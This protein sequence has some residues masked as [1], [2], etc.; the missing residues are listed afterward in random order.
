VENYLSYNKYSY[1]GGLYYQEYKTM[2][3]ALAAGYTS[4][5]VR[6]TFDAH[7]PRTLR[8]TVVL[9]GILNDPACRYKSV[10]LFFDGKLV[11]TVERTD[12][13]KQYL[14][15]TV[16]TT[17]FADGYY[18]SN[19][20]IMGMLEDGTEEAIEH[21]RG[22]DISNN[23]ECCIVKI[24]SGATPLVGA[25][26][27]LFRSGKAEPYRTDGL[28][29]IEL[30]VSATDGES[31]ILVVGEEL[32]LWRKLAPYPAGNRYAFGNDPAL[33]TIRCSGDIL[34]AADGA[35]IYAAMPDGKQYE[36]GTVAGGETRLWVDADS[37]MTFTV[38]GTGILVSE[39]IDLSGDDVVWNLDNA[40]TASITLTHDGQAPTEGDS[41]TVRRLGLE[42]AGFGEQLMDADGGTILVTPGEYSVTGYVYWCDGNYYSNYAKMELGTQSVT[43]E[44]LTLTLGSGA[45]VA[46]VSVDAETVTEGQSVS[47]TLSFTDSN[48]N[49]IAELGSSDAE[50]SYREKYRYNYLGVEEYD[51]ESETWNQINQINLNQI[52]GTATA[53]GAQLGTQPGLRRVVF[54]GEYFISGLTVADAT[55]EFSLVPQET[56]P[57]ATVRISLLDSY[58]Y[59]VYGVF[60]AT[61]LTD[62]EGNAIVREAYASESRDEA[63]I[64]LPIGESYTLTVLALDY[65]AAYLTTCTV[66]LSAAADGDEV[67]VSVTSD[68]SWIAHEIP[69]SENDES[70]YN[71]RNLALAPFADF[72]AYKLAAAGTNGHIE[73]LYVSGFAQTEL[74]LDVMPDSY[75]EVENYEYPPIFTMKHSVDLSA[76]STLQVGLPR[77]ITL[78]V[79][80]EGD[81]AVLTPV[82]TDAY[83][84]EVTGAT[85]TSRN[86]GMEGG[87]MVE[88]DMPIVKPTMVYPVITVYNSDG[89][90]IFEKNTAFL[91][92]TV[93]GLAEGSY[94]ATIVWKSSD[95][96]MSGE[97]INFTI[98]AGGEEPPVIPML[99]VPT[100]F[101]AAVV[102]GA[103]NLSWAAPVNGCA[104]YL[105]LRDGEV[106]AELNG[107]AVI[108]TDNNVVGGGYHM[109]TLYAID[110][111][112]RRSE[113]VTVGAYIST[114]ADTEA[115]AWS[116]NA[117][118]IAEI[119]NGGVNLSWS[120]AQDSG[121]GVTSYLLFCNGEEIAQLFTRRYTYSAVLPN[122]DYVFSVKA[123]DG[124]GNVSEALT[125][126]AVSVPGG[127]LGV[128]LDY[129]SNRLGYMTGKTLSI[130]VQTTADLDSAVVTVNYTRSDGSTG[131]LTPN[132]TGTGGSFTANLS[133]PDDFKQLDQVTVTCGEHVYTCL[134]APVLRCYTHVEVTVDLEEAKTLYPSAVLTL[135]AP[136]V[137]Y[138]YSYPISNMSGTV[139]DN[140]ISDDAYQLTLADSNGNVLLVRKVDFSADARINLG[141]EYARFLQLTVEGGYAG[142]AVTVTFD[143]KMVGGKLDENGT[144]VWS[145]GGRFLPVGNSATVRIP[146][147][148]YSE[149]ITFDKVVNQRTVKPEALGYEIVTIP[150]TVVDTDGK[151]ISGIEVR[152]TGYNVAD[153]KTTGADGTCVFTFANRK[154][155]TS[156]LSIQRQRD[157]Q[158]RCWASLSIAS[159]GGTAV[160]HPTPMFD[161]ILIRPVLNMDVDTES[162]SFA[163]NGNPVSLKDGVLCV[164]KNG[165]WNIGERVIVSAEYTADGV[166]Y[167]GR[168]GYELSTQTQTVELSMEHYVEVTVSLTDN[169]DPMKG[170]E[171][172]FAVYNADKE[173]VSSFSTY[174]SSS[175]V[176][177]VGGEEY[178]VLA[179]WSTIS[180]RYDPSHSAQATFIAAEGCEVA[181][182]MVVAPDYAL[183]QRFLSEN[184]FR[185]APSVS[186][187][188]SGDVRV[189]LNV[190]SYPLG[191]TQIVY[192]Y[193]VLALPEG[194][195]DIS[196]SLQYT[197]DEET[198]LVTLSDNL[199]QKYIYSQGRIS[200]TIPA[201]KVPTEFLL[202]SLTRYRYG[203]KEYLRVNNGFELADYLMQVNVP[204]RISA[205]TLQREGLM[206]DIRLPLTRPNGK[207]E[208][209]AEDTL[210]TAVAADQ[211]N[212]VVVQPENRLGELNLRVVYTA[213]NGFTL[214]R[215]ATCEITADTRP[216]LQSASVRMGYKNL[217]D[218]VNPSGQL[219]Y[220][221]NIYGALSCKATFSHQELVERVWLCGKT[222]SEFDRFELFWSE[223][224]NAF[225][226]EGQIGTLLSPFT[227]LWI[228]FDEKTR[229]IEDTANDVRGELTVDRE[230]TYT[231][232]ENPDNKYYYAPDPDLGE[233]V[234]EQAIS[235]WEKY[236]QLVNDG[237]Y[238]MEEEDTIA[239]LNELFGEDGVWNLPAV[240]DGEHHFSM[241]YGYDPETVARKL[242]SDEAFTVIINGEKRKVLIEF[243]EENGDLYICYYGLGDLFIPA[244]AETGEPEMAAA[245]SLLAGLRDFVERYWEDGMAIKEKYD[246]YEWLREG[247]KE[248]FSK[249][250]EGEEPGANDSGDPCGSGSGTGRQTREQRRQQIDEMFDE[251]WEAAK[252]VSEGISMAGG[253]MGMEASVFGEFLTQDGGAAHALF[254]LQKNRIHEIDDILDDMDEDAFP[255]TPADPCDPIDPPKKDD[256]DEDSPKNGYQPVYPLVDPSGY[257]YAGAPGYP[258]EGVKAYLYYLE[259]GG[260]TWMLWNSE[261]FGQGPNPYPSE[262]NGYYGWDVLPGKWKV[263]FEGEG[264][265]RAESIVLE[266]PPPHM[267]VDIAMTSTRNPQISDVIVKADGSI[268]IKFD[269]PMTTESVLNNAVTVTLGSEVLT[270]TLEAVDPTI[271]A[272]GIKQ[273]ALNTNIQPGLEVACVFRF[274]PDDTILAGMTVEVTVDGSVLGY[275]GLPMLSDW[276]DRLTVPEQ[277]DNM[278]LMGVERIREDEI[279][280]KIG[281]SYTL[282]EG[283]WYALFSDGFGLDEKRNNIDIRW[284]SNNEQVATVDETGKITAVG[285]GIASIIGEYDGHT[286]AFGVSVTRAPILADASKNDVKFCR[287]LNLVLG[288]AC[289]M[290]S[291]AVNYRL[292][293]PME[294]DE[295]YM[296]TAWRIKENGVVMAEGTV[297]DGESSLKII[298]TP[299]VLGTLTGEIDYQ[300]YVYTGGRWV[301][302]GSPET[303]VR[304]ITVT[305]VTD[306]T[307]HTAPA[308][309]KPG[310]A[311]DLS[312][313]RISIALSD[314]SVSTVGYEKLASYGIT[315]NLNHG[316]VPG[317]SDTVLILT[318]ART[319]ITLMIEL[320]S[321]DDDR[322]H[323]C[324]EHLTPIDG[325]GATCTEDGYKAYYK[326]SCGKLYA[327]ADCTTE[328]TLDAWKTGDGK[329]PA[330]HTYGDLV[331]AQDTIH[332]KDLLKGAVA[333]HYQCSVC[334]KYF[335][336]NYAETTL[337][338]LTG[339]TP[340]HTH[341][342]YEISADTHRSICSCGALVDSAETHD[343]TTGTSD[344]TC[345]CGAKFTGW[346]GKTYYVDAVMQTGWIQIGSDWYYFDTATGV[347]A[348]GI[349][350]VP[351]PTEAINGVTYAPNQE[352][353]DY[354]ASKGDTFLDATEAWFVF[355]EDGKFDA[356]TDIIDGKYVE[357]GMIAWHPGFVTVNY[358]LY[359]FIGD[360]ENGGNKPA[361]DIIWVTRG[362]G[363]NTYNP[364]YI[365][366]VDGQ[367]DTE[368]SGIRVIKGDNYYFENGVCALGKGLVQIGDKYIYVRSS[369]KLAIGVYYAGGV[370]Y[371]FD[372]NGYT[373]GVK[374]GLVDGKIYKNG[375]LVYGLVECDGDIYYVRSNGTFAKGVYY[376]TNTNGMEGFSK[377]DKIIFGEDGKMLE[378][379]NGIVEENGAYYYYENN[380]LRYSAGVVQMTDEQGETYYIYVRSNGQLA[381]GE[382]YPTT[383]NGY[384]EKGKYDWGKD[385]KY[386]PGK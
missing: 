40:E 199:A 150:V 30:P 71:V 170:F 117:E 295:K 318:H 238:E 148:D 293:D 121:S 58:G 95:I 17:A 9:S 195:K 366:F 70:Y 316:D 33:L 154:D 292:D 271:T 83:G 176:T 126:E 109:Y 49:A 237:L 222:E 61:M 132:V 377:G 118:L 173:W 143:G 37:P 335:T 224:E 74:Y 261:D 236:V 234:Q 360:V 308:V 21:G 135:Y 113:A 359:Y 216:V 87:D 55:A 206:L 5:D 380:H 267:D 286:I 327:D 307:L 76:A 368:F 103:V 350:R 298:Y 12:G 108:Y 249:D 157:D 205:S 212:R 130:Q 41:G 339:E 158:G 358:E 281:D 225:L 371:E 352:D 64:K 314:G 129:A 8:G 133:L 345:V 376:I 44:G 265:A 160:L 190:T 364:G 378:I 134:T 51:T 324:K 241:N 209:Y 204:G 102:D 175:K 146:E 217:G 153:A 4:S 25:K 348:E 105:L 280:L 331:E 259:E 67:S 59:N 320:Q 289:Y 349:S 268:Y 89:V 356:I 322:V 381:T 317:E 90:K 6:F 367:V 210:L 309:V 332:T 243:E 277:D 163:V 282:S 119:G 18:Y 191:D 211:H 200:F 137:G 81:S 7:L 370:K 230:L 334:E 300:K 39:T 11:G 182:D 162:V 120:R 53:A 285:G 312:A 374:N 384:L 302:T 88:G 168:A 319:G 257:I 186:M 77:T 228:E 239:A 125:A 311:L 100:T 124:A 50:C 26:G 323:V 104:G 169:G 177:L 341:S 337:L 101:R 73:F 174:Q 112:G 247:L 23:S 28:G 313:M 189:S 305:E 141:A 107:D 172:Y 62:A 184:G 69:W 171:R 80:T 254:E 115:P 187:L 138:A 343:Y 196:C 240:T 197:F 139:V 274:V 54:Y 16:D 3:D 246:E 201:E 24:T 270:G 357:N 149:E 248:E 362:T 188:A 220:S 233:A 161:R 92:V 245:G 330:G 52:P 192:A 65:S 260:E 10:S 329:I 355:G 342:E 253:A 321:G 152:I 183:P 328:I 336:E 263:V 68:D 214:S 45:P 47:V 165:W 147:L 258:V 244:V 278:T 79:E 159:T 106:L 333:A 375:H 97:Q 164:G 151:G 142:L 354:A 66:D 82:I 2:A 344:R 291:S 283:D 232:K 369:G 215:E 325:S 86:G 288:K 290:W 385:G 208:V 13:A 379:K 20:S 361:D 155:Y 27:W 373:S 372:E 36:V 178:T 310:E 213:D 144:A 166:T 93:E 272:L 299:T 287:D 193:H 140:V 114:G 326:C 14:S 57:A 75:D 353:I 251:G 145:S 202:R 48:G 250:P 111:E 94:A 29:E 303:A 235:D 98:G 207:L 185:S 131:V 338:A 315:M 127:I 63:I 262:E 242:A 22:F 15:F 136:S 301:A 296:P 294:G 110:K 304:N 123:V 32:L 181:L 273:A 351:Y 219:Y 46:A 38:C 156:Y 255:D 116:S 223:E 42:I 99:Q 383:L 382:Y 60:A 365:I 269:H 386:Y 266:V 203:G 122:I 78:T 180:R 226:G 252:A 264:Y 194:A 34:A 35:A 340:T 221:T 218:L 96:N 19:I 72:P 167:E 128:Q 179:G 91:P 346:E 84:H 31:S 347:R 43:G 279:Y 231:P 363:A 276:S 275:N 284:Y 256:N 227:A 297:A 85:Y 1:L 306:L 229:S 56:R 198:G